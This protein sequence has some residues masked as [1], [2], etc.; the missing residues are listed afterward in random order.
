M[1]V[2]RLISRSLSTVP[3]NSV[4]LSQFGGV[5]GNKIGSLHA[6]KAWRNKP[7]FRKDED[8]IFKTGIEACQLLNSEAR[9]RD[10]VF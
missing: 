5:H 4:G 7:L 9:R 6:S 10:E 1:H 3:T 2:R 8:K